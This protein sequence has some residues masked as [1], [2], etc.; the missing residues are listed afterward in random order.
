MKQDIIKI[1]DKDGNIIAEEHFAQG[2]IMEHI[3][4]K[5]YEFKDGLKSDVNVLKVDGDDNGR[6]IFEFFSKNITGINGI[7]YSRFVFKEGTNTVSTS[8][9]KNSDISHDYIFRNFKHLGIISHYHSHKDTFKL[10]SGDKQW[11]K[12][13]KTTV[14][15]VKTYV[16]HNDKYKQYNETGYEDKRIDN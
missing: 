16:F 14:G 9:L 11:H 10:S 3:Y 15:N 2:T 7:E 12:F 4:I 5:D 1:T 8:H 6:K 13:L